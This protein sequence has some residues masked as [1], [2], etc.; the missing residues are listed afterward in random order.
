M[1][2]FGPE[3]DKRYLRKCFSSIGWILVVYYL[4]VNAAV[5]VSVILEVL[6]RMMAQLQA[7]NMDGLMDAAIEAA[8]SAWGYFLAAAVGILILLLWKKNRFWRE[9]IWHRG[10]VM[11]PGSFFSLLVIFL[12]GQ[13]IYQVIVIALELSLNSLGLTMMEGMESMSGSSDNLSMFL[14][15]GILA[16]VTEELIFRGLIQ[17]SL[18]PY[19]K[20]FAI[21]CSAFTF[22]IF[23]GNI[24]Q[25]P[26]AF[27]V[28]LVLGYVSA[29]YSIAWAMVLHLINNM[30]LG[31]TMTRL[32]S[33][34]SETGA[35]L[36]IWGILLACAAAAIIVAAVNRRKIGEYLQRERMHPLHVKCFFSSAGVITL[37]VIMGISMIATCFV[38]ITPL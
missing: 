22:G 6:I 11:T 20:K 24:L 26:Y 7:G 10:K 23:H 31:D 13:V 32:T 25:A 27:A 4:I 3:W 5:I 1:Y 30:I 37:M 36:V 16:P 33:G 15:V 34:M 9:E 19:G 2:M 21:F 14:Y 12:S 35:V 18:L 8:S 29:E 28:G 17:R 38:L